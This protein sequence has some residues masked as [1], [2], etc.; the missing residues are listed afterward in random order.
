[1]K[2]FKFISVVCFSV[3]V[4][5]KAM[6]MGQGIF[7]RGDVEVVKSFTVK[8]VSPQTGR[9]NGEKLTVVPGKFKMSL[10]ISNSEH[11]RGV[12]PLF[13]GCIGERVKVRA[14]SLTFGAGEK[15]R[16]IEFIAPVE[17]LKD[18]TAVTYAKN[19]KQS[20]NVFMRTSKSTK[21]GNY[22]TEVEECS[23]KVSCEDGYYGRCTYAVGENE[24]SYHDEITTT[25]MVV[26]LTGLKNELLAT[27]NG[28]EDSTRTV[29]EGETKCVLNSSKYDF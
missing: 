17:F 8:G 15:A 26:K 6:A 12:C 13:I 5:G 23:V 7:G 9:S 27:F 29:Q 19:S 10:G 1:M 25:Y 22:R 21:K 11:F 28:K 18:G 14:M 16:N 3:L 20:F 2:V 24:V 4:G